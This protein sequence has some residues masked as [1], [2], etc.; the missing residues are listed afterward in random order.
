MLTRQSTSIKLPFLS[1]SKRD[2]E[3]IVPVELPGST[4]HSIV[5]STLFTAGRYLM[6]K[7][8]ADLELSL[9]SR[10]SLQAY[11]AGL[12]ADGFFGV[13]IDADPES[14]LSLAELRGLVLT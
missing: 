3:T 6:E 4:G 5:F 1:L 7:H 13:C 8:S 12:E 9:I 2:A 10:Q 14:T 11:I